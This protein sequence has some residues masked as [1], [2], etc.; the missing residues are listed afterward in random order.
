MHKNGLLYNYPT[1]KGTSGAPNA[2]LVN[3]QYFVRAIHAR[4]IT[5]IGKNMMGY[6]LKAGLQLHGRMFENILR[7]F[8]YVVSEYWL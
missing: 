5:N 3:G 8:T 4:N 7:N 2:E 1:E 6:N